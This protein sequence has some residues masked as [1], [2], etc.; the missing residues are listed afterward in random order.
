MTTEP[1]TK[2]DFALEAVDLPRDDASARHA[3]S[4]GWCDEPDDGAE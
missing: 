4:S 3:D 1:G 2:Y